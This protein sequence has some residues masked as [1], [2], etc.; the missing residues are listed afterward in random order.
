VSYQE[1][2][3]GHA[4]N[5][6]GGEHIVCEVEGDI[7]QVTCPRTRSSEA[8]RVPRPRGQRGFESVCSWRSVQN[9]TFGQ[10]RIQGPL[11]RGAARG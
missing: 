11:S 7:G 3:P 6:G 1:V 2:L 9:W 5:A 8:A 10:A 4:D